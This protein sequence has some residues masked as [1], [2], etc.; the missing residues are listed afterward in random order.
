[1]HATDACASAR[2]HFLDEAA[3]PR[4]VANETA[5][6][7]ERLCRLRA[8]DPAIGPLPGSLLAQF[9]QV[10]GS[11]S[12]CDAARA[13][14]RAADDVAARYRQRFGHPPPYPWHAS[15]PALAATS[16]GAN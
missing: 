3:W 15:S 10:A 5:L 8:D 4:H 1:M 12:T 13:P 7:F 14:T 9:A 6:E 11:D 2:R 16:P